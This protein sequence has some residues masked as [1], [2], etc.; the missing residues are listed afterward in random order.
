MIDNGAQFGLSAG[1]SVKNSRF[2]D[3]SGRRYTET[4]GG[5]AAK[6]VQPYGSLIATISKSRGTGGLE[7]SCVA[8]SGRENP[9][10]PLREQ[11]AGRPLFRAGAHVVAGASPPHRPREKSG[12]CRD[13]NKS[14]A[15]SRP[16]SPPTRSAAHGTWRTPAPFVPKPSRKTH[17]FHVFVGAARL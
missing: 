1:H 3:S 9:D 5:S 13:S 15:E 8:G 4:I 12:P 2:A 14:A 6:F 17:W 7:P 10:Q 11:R 16:R